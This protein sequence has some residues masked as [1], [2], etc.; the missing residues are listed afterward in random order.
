MTNV[1]FQVE[2]RIFLLLIFSWLTACHSPTEISCNQP[3]KNIDF[4]S[5]LDTINIQ[6]IHPNNSSNLVFEIFAKYQLNDSIY[7]SPLKDA[8]VSI[9]PYENN[10]TLL[11]DS[12][13]QIR[14]EVKSGKIKYHIG[15][16]GYHSYSDT[17][18]I[19]P[20]KIYKLTIVLGKND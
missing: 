1:N 3:K 2:S 18:T 8:I 7:I 12:Q 5:R 10:Q 11:T 17:L 9:K 14:L 15:Y 4:S 6:K 20:E 19:A 13:G 16:Y